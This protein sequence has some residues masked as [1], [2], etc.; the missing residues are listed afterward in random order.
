MNVVPFIE[1]ENWII[2]ANN[3]Y[4]MQGSRNGN[5][6]ISSTQ[7]SKTL[8]IL[9]PDFITLY[10]ID[11]FK[12]ADD[13]PKLKIFSDEIEFEKFRQF[14]KYLQNKKKTAD[15]DITKSWYKNKNTTYLPLVQ[16]RDDN[17]TSIIALECH[18]NL[19]IYDKERNI[20]Y[21]SADKIVTPMSL[22]KK[23]CRI[24]CIFKM[25]YIYNHGGKFGVKKH[26]VELTIL[27]TL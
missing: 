23:S 22:V 17:R 10:G 6:G 1:L 15:T 24:S 2:E 13:V 12:G 14:D 9:I 4:K 25:S 11:N 3:T 18:D 26:L 16:D 5:I 20:L 19:V 27:D 8:S 21:P 7:N